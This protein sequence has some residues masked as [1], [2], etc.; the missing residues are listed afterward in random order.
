MTIRKRLTWYPKRE[1]SGKHSK[2]VW[3]KLNKAKSKKELKEALLLCMYSVQNLED[4]LVELR[5]FV[6]EKVERS[7]PK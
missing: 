2:Y 5:D 3:K 7:Y 4:R 6:G 1:L